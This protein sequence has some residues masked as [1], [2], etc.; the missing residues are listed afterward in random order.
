M[1]SVHDPPHDVILSPMSAPIFRLHAATASYT[2]SVCDS[3][4]LDLN[5]KLDDPY[6]AAL[7]CTS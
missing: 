1:R 4:A 5:A 3:F 2:S 6:C 7:Y